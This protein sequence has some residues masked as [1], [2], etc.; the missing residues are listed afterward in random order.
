M[1]LTAVLTTDNFAS[2]PESA[3]KASGAFPVDQQTGM[4]P[5]AVP[6]TAGISGSVCLGKDLSV[7]RLVVGD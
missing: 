4:Y 1:P 3:N 2:H 7:G 5:R 6:A